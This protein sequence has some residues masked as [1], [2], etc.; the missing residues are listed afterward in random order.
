MP[1]TYKYPRPAVT[2]DVVVFG[3]HPGDERIDEPE[4]L[5]VL[6]IERAGSPHKGKLA[7]PGG[8]VNMAE[9]LDAAARRELQEETGIKPSHIEQLYTFGAPKRDPRGRVIS[10]AYYALV[11]SDQIVPRAGSDASSARWYPVDQALRRPLA[12]D[13]AEIL[14]TAL[15]RLRGK[16]RYAPIGFGLLPEFFTI[17][18]LH[19]LY[20]AI[21]GRPIDRANFDKLIKRTGVLIPDGMESG[22][23]HRPGRL[24]SF[25]RERYEREGFVFEL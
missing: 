24:Y 16:I 6:L 10:V 7:I 4:R 5:N 25:D 9:D 19:S 17:G 13:H 11:R 3:F 18:Q 20:V 1:H 2:V 8:F 12:F 21:L 15:A 23:R 22:A 14:K